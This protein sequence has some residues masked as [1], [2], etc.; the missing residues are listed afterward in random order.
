MKKLS[1]A[2]NDNMKK[3]LSAEL[4]VFKPDPSAGMKRL[5]DKMQSMST[6]MK[7]LKHDVIPIINV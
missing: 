6:D 7:I 4:F 1:D 2:M 5:S 3:L